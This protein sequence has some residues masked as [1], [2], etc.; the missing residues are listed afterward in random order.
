MGCWS[1]FSPLLS[2]MRQLDAAWSVREF[3]AELVSPLSCYETASLHSHK[4]QLT[5]EGRCG[6]IDLLTLVRV[7]HLDNGL[8]DFRTDFLKLDNILKPP[9]RFYITFTYN[10]I[11]VSRILMYVKHIPPSSSWSIYQKVIYT[12]Y[13]HKT[14]RVEWVI[15]QAPKASI[16]K[17]IPKINPF[18]IFRNI[19]YISLWT[20]SQ[21]IST[22]SNLISPLF[23]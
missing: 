13:T 23:S 3:S 20:K 7:G 12:D 1:A 19:I 8:K 16:L 10:Y 6:Q 22:S 21:D 18:N 15:T 17:C 11:R 9:A 5:T 4:S 14:L 2:W